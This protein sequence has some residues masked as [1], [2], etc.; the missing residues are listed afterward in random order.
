MAFTRAFGGGTGINL[1]DLTKWKY[2]T[3]VSV[4]ASRSPTFLSQANVRPNACIIWVAQNNQQN[5]D[6]WTNINPETGEINNSQIYHLTQGNWQLSTAT[7]NI[8]GPNAAN[9]YTVQTTGMT[10]G[11]AASYGSM[12]YTKLES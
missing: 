12:L 6:I 3:I 9:R 7:I 1:I 11:S 2:A 10:Y 5:T 4:A 8:T